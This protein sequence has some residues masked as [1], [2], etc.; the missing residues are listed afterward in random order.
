[1]PLTLSP[2]HIHFFNISILRFNS[3]FTLVTNYLAR[4]FIFADSLL[5]SATRTFC[6]LSWND[7]TEGGLILSSEERDM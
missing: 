2:Y 5:R 7:E 1:F 6:N 4:A 3:S